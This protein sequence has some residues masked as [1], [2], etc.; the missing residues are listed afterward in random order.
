MLKQY[1]FY[2]EY[3]IGDKFTTQGRTITEGD[4]VNFAGVAGDFHPIH[5]D[6]EYAKGTLFG[7]RV[8]HWTL[9]LSISVGLLG[10]SQL[11][12]DSFMAF[13]GLEH[14]R[15]LAPVKAGE[16]IKVD[17]EVAAKRETQK[18]D[19]GIV[20]LHHAVRNQRGETVIDFSTNIMVRRRG[21]SEPLG[22]S[23]N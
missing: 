20:T 16:T 22:K 21:A 10:S 4:I 2:E 15:A 11:L 14:L 8:A 3:G 23:S 12:G 9:T 17:I 19:R 13:L 5:V 6:E 1:Q 18:A 7:T